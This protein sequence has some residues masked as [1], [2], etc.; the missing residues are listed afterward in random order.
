MIIAAVSGGPDSMA[1][2]DKYKNDIS[3]VCHINYNKRPTALRDEEI[4]NNYC[5][6]NHIK[7]FTLFCSKEVYASYKSEINFQSKARKIRYDFF[8]KTAKELGADTLY[9]AHNKDDFVETAIMQMNKKSKSLFYGIAKDGAYHDLLIKRPL[10][11]IRKQSLENYCISNHIPYGI[12]ESNLTDLYTRN[13]IRKKIKKMSNDEF[14]KVLK[15]IADYNK[16][17]SSLRLRVKKAYK[18]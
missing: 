6:L 3:A 7:C 11:N 14:K 8:V 15:E 16:A 18:T 4:V 9:I 17:N 13:I 12:D 10:I 5:K 1:M 2:L